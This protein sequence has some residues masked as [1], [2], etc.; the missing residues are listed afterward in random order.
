[1]DYYKCDECGLV[2]DEFSMDFKYS[3]EHGKCLC[4]ECITQDNV[5]DRL[6]PIPTETYSGSSQGAHK[7]EEI[8]YY[9]SHS[10]IDNLLT[11]AKS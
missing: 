8:H 3:S 10:R 4:N 6:E 7:N 2:F 5:D 1:M 9:H 11:M